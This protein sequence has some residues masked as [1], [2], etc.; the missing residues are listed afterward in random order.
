[1]GHRNF[2]TPAVLVLREESGFYACALRT[3]V[4][5]TDF[6]S[7]SEKICKYEF[8]FFKFGENYRVFDCEFHITDIVGI[9][10]V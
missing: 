8:Q 5:S 7:S 1:M 2:R 10:Q 9:M 3:A 4:N 6:Y